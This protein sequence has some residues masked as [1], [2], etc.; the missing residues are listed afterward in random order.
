MLPGGNVLVAGGVSNNGTSLADAE[1]FDVKARQWTTVAPMATPRQNHQ[2]PDADPDAVFAPTHIATQSRWSC[3]GPPPPLTGLHAC[4][5]V[6]HHLRA[7][8]PCGNLACLWPPQLTALQDGRVLA[9]G[10]S[11]VG[12]ATPTS[13]CELF[14]PATSR[15]SP[16]GAMQ[17]ARYQHQATLLPSGK[18]GPPYSSDPNQTLFQR[19]NPMLKNP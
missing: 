6:T 2:V 5:P 8:A 15:F 7:L 1:V 12:F 18:V 13:S 9:I 19:N 3:R 17:V 16:T 14:D 10:G 11:P 4:H